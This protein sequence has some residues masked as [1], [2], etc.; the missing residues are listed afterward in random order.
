MDQDSYMFISFMMSP[1]RK[2]KGANSTLRT[3]LGTDTVLGSCLLSLFNA[4]RNYGCPSL[5]ASHKASLSN[6]PQGAAIKASSF[7]PIILHFS[8]LVQVF[9]SY[10]LFDPT[11]LLQLQYTTVET[12]IFFLFEFHRESFTLTEH[13]TIKTTHRMSG[14]ASGLL[15]SCFGKVC[16][17]VPSCTGSCQCPKSEQ[18]TPASSQPQQ[19]VIDTQPPVIGPMKFERSATSSNEGSELSPF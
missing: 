18:Q 19:G 4:A 5:F 6:R 16:K 17:D 9:L 12:L 8:S 15:S 2:S 3:K 10:T 11:F 13:S 14:N 1:G 7:P